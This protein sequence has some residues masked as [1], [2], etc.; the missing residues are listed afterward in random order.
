[1]IYD[2]EI[3]YPMSTILFYLKTKSLQIVCVFHNLNYDGKFLC[4]E[5]AKHPKIKN[6]QILAKS[7]EKTKRFRFIDSFAHIPSSLEKIVSN[8]IAHGKDNFH[9]LRA[10]FPDEKHFNLLWGKGK[11][12][13]EYLSNVNI[14][15]E[16]LPKHEAFFS[17][18][19]N[20]NIS[21]EEYE[22]VKDIWETFQLRTLKDLLKLYVRQ[23]VLLLAD[24]INF[25][26]SMVR[27]NYDLECLAYY[28]APALSM[29]AALK[30]NTMSIDLI[31]DPGQYMFLEK[32]IRGGLSMAST[33]YAKANNKYM[34][35][36][37]P[38]E[39]S[40]YIFHID[41]T[42]LYGWSLSQ[43]LPCSNFKWEDISLDELKK[44]LE[45]YNHSTSKKGYICEV[46][47]TIPKSLHD[48]FDDNPPI[49]DQLLITYD[50]LSPWA[51]NLLKGK[52]FTPEKK[53]SPS[54][55]D[56]EGYVC[57][58]KT[59]QL[60]IELGIHITSVD[61]TLSFDQ[62]SWLFNYIE[63]NSDKRA[64][65]KSKVERDFFKLIINSL[66]GKTLES[67]RR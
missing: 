66:F 32:S 53:L 55:Y 30:M 48:F 10:E 62:D 8:L 61:K 9:A 46:S 37:N 41:V 43:Q 65:A 64:N 45:S 26:R 47:L 15:D 54:L 50:M 16:P 40:S 19:N 23:D 5:L 25:H 20:K 44:I 7:A 17:T 34:S 56:K 29:D 35:S 14:L 2:Y 11:F 58:I 6:L 57:H 4:K 67:V 60:Y 24:C 63:F 49:C 21:E 36:H 38:G 52:R 51:K 27:N 3:A 59:L 13:Y 42:N 28:S 12:P 22:L 18:L 39:K 1:M 31:T 33:H